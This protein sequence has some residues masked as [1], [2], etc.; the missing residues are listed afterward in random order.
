MYLNN[1]SIILILAVILHGFTTKSQIYVSV[2]G[3]DSNPGTKKAPLAT[4]TAARDAI[5]KLKQDKTYTGPLTVIIGDGIY[6]MNSSLVLTPDDSGVN[7]RPVIYKAGRRANPVF[8]GGKKITGFTVGDDGIWKIKVPDFGNGN[9]RFGQLYVNGKRATLARTPNEDFLKIEKVEQEIIVK[10]TGRVADKAQ[11][12]ISFNSDNFEK[13]K[14]ITDDEAGL[15][16]FRAFH[17]WDFTVRH[18]DSIDAGKMAVYTTGK[19]M[20]P[21]NPL[22]KGTRVIFENFKAALDSPGEW[23]LSNDGTLYYFPREGE[24]VNTADVVIPV[25]NK[26][27]TVNGDAENDNYVKDVTFEGLS[28]EHCNYTMPP[29]GFEPAQA[30]ASVDAAIYLAGARNVNFRNCSIEKTGQHALWFGKGCN[31]CTVSHCYINDVGGGGIYLGET[32]PQ[33]GVLQTS[34]MKIEN[35]IIHS[36]G[37]ELPPAVG[38]WVGNS[39]DNLVTHN[40]I[41]NFYYTGISVGWIWGYAPS[42][43]KRNIITFNNIH[44]IGWALLSDMA[45]VYTLGKSEGTKINNNVVHHVHAYSYGGWGLYTDEGSSF[46]EMKNNLV[47]STKTGGFHQHYGEENVITNNIFAFARLYQLQCTR[48]EDHLSFTLNKNIVVFDEGAVLKGA[49][50]K[51]KIK[52]DRNI[53]WNYKDTVYN[54]NGKTFDKWKENS[55]HDKNSLIADPLFKDAEDHDFRIKNRSVIQKTGFIPFD[56]TKAGVTGKKRWKKKAQLPDEILKEFDR[57]VEENM[58]QK[59]GRD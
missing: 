38:V 23:F 50:D 13:L 52:M 2:N 27:I 28:F 48:V 1:K 47:Y 29:E 14:G 33:E 11:Q 59:T 42:P 5:R 53:Y 37:K 16:R 25:L 3:N 22:K 34:H 56:Y 6:E 15:V 24:N 32:E 31:H 17:K 20:K 41:G 21:W 39:S 7:G 18:L 9:F 10:G 19:G 45:A 8:S 55:G 58:T 46:I 35:N 4:L 51:I 43:A 12:T 30:A 54:F 57:V 26:L 36:G 44:H 49:W 40:D